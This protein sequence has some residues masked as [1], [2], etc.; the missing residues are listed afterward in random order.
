MERR[1]AARHSVHSNLF[2][3]DSEG[4]GDEDDF[5]E[6]MKRWSMRSSGQSRSVR[7][8]LLLGSGGAEDQPLP[9]HPLSRTNSMHASR[10]NL[11][12]SE[13]Q[14]WLDLVFEAI[15]LGEVDLVRFRLKLPLDANSA[16]AQDKCHPLCQVGAASLPC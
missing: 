9:A 11:V 15:E 16:Y 5:E 13:E 2:S 14:R 1:R 7:S 8:S 10:E 12:E 6:S 4:S 3:S